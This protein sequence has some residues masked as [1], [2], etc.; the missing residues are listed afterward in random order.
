M[1]ILCNAFLHELI[2]TTYSNN[3]SF[4]EALDVFRHDLKFVTYQTT[5][6]MPKISRGLPCRA[7]QW[8]V[9]I[10]IDI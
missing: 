8:N 1:A 4:G 2:N 7:V 3:E 6:L 5:Y 10:K 9:H